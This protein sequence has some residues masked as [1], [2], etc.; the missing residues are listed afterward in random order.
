MNNM[1]G[2]ANAHFYKNALPPAPVKKMRN[3]ITDGLFRQVMGLVFT[4]CCL[5]FWAWLHHIC[6]LNAWVSFLR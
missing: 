3:F 1:N 5:I 2:F 6:A 4:N